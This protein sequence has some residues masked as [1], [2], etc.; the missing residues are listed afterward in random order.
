MT[1]LVRTVAGIA[2]L[3]AA[4]LAITIANAQGATAD[5]AAAFPVQVATAD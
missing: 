4:Y 5:H 1:I 3:S 2:L